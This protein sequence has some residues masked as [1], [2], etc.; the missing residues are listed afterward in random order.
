MNFKYVSDVV[1][2]GASKVMGDL[3]LIEKMGFDCDRPVCQSCKRCLCIVLECRDT[4]HTK[5]SQFAFMENQDCF[6]Q[7]EKTL[8]ECRASCCDFSRCS[9]LIMSSWLCPKAIRSSTYFLFDRTCGHAP[10]GI[11]SCGK[12]LASSNVN[13]GIR[14]ATTGVMAHS[15]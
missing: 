15:N 4:K 11:R 8:I 5:W 1:H 13:F 9:E 7:T 14:R 6:L 2:H 3:H 10:M 12:H